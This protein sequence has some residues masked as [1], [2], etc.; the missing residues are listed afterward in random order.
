MKNLLF[1][2]LIALL[3]FAAHAEKVI[4]SGIAKSYQGSTISVMY[5]TDS[6]T[7]TS[8]KIA[9]FKVDAN[10]KFLL[11]LE[12]EKTQLIF[13]PLGV[14]KGFLY[15]EP[16]KRYELRFPP[17]QELTPAQKLN[18]FFEADELMLGLANTTPNELNRNIRRLD[19]KLDSFIN[20]N[21]HRIYRKK[22]KSEGILFSKQVKQEF[23][24]IKNQFF[25]DYLRYRLG[26]LEFLSNPIAFQKIENDFFKDQE[27]QVN[28]PAYMSLYKKQY[29][30]FLNGYFKQ[31]ESLTLSNAFKSANSYAEIKK[32]M[33]KYPAYSNAQ[34]L[35]MIIATSTFDSFTRK[36]IGKDKSLSILQEI[37]KASSN[38]YNKNLCRNFISKITHLQKNYPA[39][40]FKFGGV[41]LA[42]YKGKYLYLNFC[43]TQSYPCLQ[44]FK[45]M[46]KLK[47]QFGKHVEFLSIACDWD[48]KKWLEFSKNNRYTWKFVHIGN[49]HHLI[50]EY[51]IKA[52]PSYVL[53]DPKG[54]I[55]KAA[56]PGP[57]ENIHLEFI[58]IA[59]DAARNAH[60]K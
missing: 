39:P 40:E 59:R 30:N 5:H 16:G 22:E 42:D 29:G 27:I 50:H 48:V 1:L 31:K 44:D 15:I 20:Q 49:Q 24:N 23:G 53:I 54:N 43:N 13:L 10:G 3:S 19:D 14:Y 47:K 17:K 37:I 33:Q 25:I 57:K 52:F 6:F 11:E 38:D 9:D 8:K 7:Y 28:N 34:L 55:V 56:A 36:F 60:K 41:Q 21:F 12:V 58:K 18:P 51:K 4:L 32:L 26:F 2:T 35:D 46:V 45:E